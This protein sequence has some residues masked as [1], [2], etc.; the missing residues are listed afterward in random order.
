MLREPN[1]FS[2]FYLY[3]AADSY[4]PPPHFN[5]TSYQLKK[6]TLSGGIK[7]TFTYGAG[8]V[9]ANDVLPPSTSTLSLSSNLIT[10]DL[11]AKRGDETLRSRTH[12]RPR[13]L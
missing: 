7:G 10:I 9:I 13:D 4:V 1:N 8:E 12:L 5:Q 11:S 6:A 2:I 3:N